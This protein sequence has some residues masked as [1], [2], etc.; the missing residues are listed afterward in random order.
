M[1]LEAIPAI[2]RPLTIGFER[3]LSLLTTVRARYLVHL[4][5]RAAASS[6]IISHIYYSSLTI[7]GQIWLRI[8][9]IY[10][11]WSVDEESLAVPGSSYFLNTY[12]AQ[13]KYSRPPLR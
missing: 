7:S 6:S 12:M 4:P 5:W 1:F 8:F 3:D 9:H 10:S 11:C 13:L 2:D